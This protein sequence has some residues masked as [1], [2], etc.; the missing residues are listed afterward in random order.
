MKFLAGSCI[1]GIL[2]LEWL[3][4]NRGMSKESSNERDVP[5]C[6][7]GASG[8]HGRPSGEHFRPSGDPAGELPP[9][10]DRPIQVDAEQ[11]TIG[12]LDLLATREILAELGI[13]G[14]RAQE[15]IDSAAIAEPGVPASS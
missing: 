8:H 11:L 15:L 5:E 4:E 7:A 12:E 3:C 10:A 9:R 1:V 13:D 2:F 14:S 6:A